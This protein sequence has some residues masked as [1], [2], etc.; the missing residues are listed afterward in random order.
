MTKAD[1]IEKVADSVIG[2][3]ES[4]QKHIE[5]IVDDYDVHIT[6]DELRDK[7]L[8]K[9]VEECFGCGW[10]VQSDELIDEDDNV[11]GCHDCFVR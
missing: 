4:L 5:I 6:E 1:A 2:T 11:V 3:C 10:W 7:L 8:E 9:N